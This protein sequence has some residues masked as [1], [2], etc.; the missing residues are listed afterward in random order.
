MLMLNYVIFFAHEFG[1][2]YQS[3]NT[4]LAY[5]FKYGISSAV[6]QGSTEGDAN[7]RGF[8]NLRITQP[9]TGFYSRNANNPYTWWEAG[10]GSILWPFMWLWN[11]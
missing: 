6:Y 4:G 7:R 5:L 11:K 8:G 9:T 3:R 1:H 2:T 10:F